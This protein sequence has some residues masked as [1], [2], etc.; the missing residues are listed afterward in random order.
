MRFEN[1]ALCKYVKFKLEIFAFQNN[2]LAYQ[3]FDN[4]CRIL[5]IFKYINVKTKYIIKLKM[6]IYFLAFPLC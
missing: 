1:F 4:F 5:S 3:E 6:K 2:I